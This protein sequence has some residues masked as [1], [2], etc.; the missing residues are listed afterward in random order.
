MEVGALVGMIAVEFSKDGSLFPVLMN[1]RVLFLK[2]MNNPFSYE[3]RGDV[4]GDNRE[5]GGV[6][7][8]VN[9]AMSNGGGDGG[10]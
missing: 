1:N 4:V 7:D 8:G 2:I 10:G 9:D 5:F 3:M 6:S